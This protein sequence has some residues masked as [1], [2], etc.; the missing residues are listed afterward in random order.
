MLARYK[1]GGGIIELVK[2][3]E[4]SAEPKKSQLLSMVRSEDP[5]FAAQVEA[6]I[7]NYEKLRALPENIIA[8]I[9]AAMSAKFMALVLTGETPEFVALCEKCL[10]KNFSEY[11]AEK[12]VLLGTT[13]TPAQV[14][15]ARRKMI[16]EARKL[17]ASGAIRLLTPEAEAAAAA[18]ASASSGKLSAASPAGSSGPSGTASGDVGCPPTESFAL[19]PAPPG[20]TGERFDTFLKQALGMNS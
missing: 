13:P 1:K 19:D 5:E 4:D 18:G 12:D 10:G 2:L 3:I 9:V 20:L 8:E 16:S 17:E 11:K 7:F 15:A 6:K 14:E